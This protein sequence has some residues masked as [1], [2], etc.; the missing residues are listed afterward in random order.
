MTVIADILGVVFIVL[1]LMT[2]VNFVVGTF[3]RKDNE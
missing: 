2:I 3:P 1:A